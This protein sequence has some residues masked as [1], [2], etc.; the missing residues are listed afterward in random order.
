MPMF[1]PLPVTENHDGDARRVGVELEMGGLDSDRIAAA[2]TAELG[3]RFEPDNAFSG[4][5]YDTALGD[6]RVELDAS[7]LTEQRH[8]ELLDALGIELDENAVRAKLESVLAKLAGLVVPHELVGPPVPME[9]LD[10]IDAIRARQQWAG[11]RGTGASPLY[12]FGLQFNIEIHS[13]E[14]ASL[15]AVLQA[16]LLRFDGIVEREAIDFSR[17]LTP[18]VQP[19]PDDCLARF[20]DPEY[21][22]NLETLI[23][24][25]L[26][27][28]PTRNRPLDLLPLLAWLD[29]SR[30][31]AAPVERELIK[32]R[33]AWHYRLPNCRIDDPDWSLHTAWAEWVE[34]ERLAADHKRLHT[35]LCDRAHDAKGWIE[36]LFD[37][38]SEEQGSDE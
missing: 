28:T 4:P 2:V 1:E 17:S 25:D 15:L 29:E 11:A 27:L 13:R 34:V 12:A 16:F 31:M 37:P 20:L 10:R 18:Y 3:G 26:A 22:P 23:D 35:A 24:K 7:L 38:R 33:P 5:I 14:A 19:F 32:P 21:D 36:R 6:F 9:A 30:V 8:L